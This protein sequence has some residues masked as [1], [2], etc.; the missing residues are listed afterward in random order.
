MLDVFFE[1]YK[2]TKITVF[3]Q[4]NYAIDFFYWFLKKF[5]RFQTVLPLPYFVEKRFVAVLC[6]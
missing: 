4:L 6:D 5:P 3:L 2:A 1:V